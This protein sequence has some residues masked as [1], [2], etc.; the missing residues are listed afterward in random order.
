MSMRIRLGCLCICALCVAANGFCEQSEQPI[1]ATVCQL[2]SDAAAYNHKLIAV[3][4]FVSHAFEDFSLFDPKCSSWPGVWLEYGGT[5]KS[6]TMYCCGVTA[7]RRR[8]K[9]LVVENIPIP[10]LANEQFEQF[11]KAIQPPFRSGQQGAVVY[12]TLVGKFFAGRRLE[13]RRD[14]PWGGYGHMGCCTLLAIQEI[15]SLDTDNRGELDYGA[16]ADQPVVEKTGC[17]FRD[18]LLHDQTSALMQWQHEAEAG[19]HEWAFSDPARVASNTLATVLKLD[20]TSLTSLRLIH[21]TQGRKIYQW[22]PSARSATYMV[23]VSRPYWISF[24]SRDRTQVAWT[25]IA[26]YES[27]CSGKNAITRIR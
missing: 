6:G 8:A 5:S 10:L 1:E 24:Y 14:K 19:K 17:G 7:D 3:S 18:L 9:E 23:V 26:A 25:T 15:K 4:G 27:S 20:A 12:A 16:S 21:E 13:Y 11:D 22:K 2:K